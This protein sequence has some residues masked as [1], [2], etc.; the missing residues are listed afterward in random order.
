MFAGG[1]ARL[2]VT[3]DGEAPLELTVEPWADTY[4][5]QRQQTYVV[6]THSPVADGSW[7]GT[8]RG[9]EPFQVVYRPDS[10]TVWANGQCFHLADRAGHAIDAADWQCPAQNVAS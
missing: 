9:D 5:I 6:V 3:N 2:L 8:L 7:C 1:T 4:Q 10:V